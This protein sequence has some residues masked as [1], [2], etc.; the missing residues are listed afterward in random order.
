[1]SLWLVIFASGLV[2]FLIRLSFVGLLGQRAVSPAVRR[3][4]GFVPPA[5]L[6][7]IILPE[8][9]IRDGALDFSLGNLRLL[10]G[11]AA[12][13]VAWRTR[14]PLWTIAA[15]MLVLWFLTALR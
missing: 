5:V 12:W 3:V 15:G 14:S 1:M 10:A 11:L 6:S 2:T 4:L 8:M 13:V 9:L 7:A